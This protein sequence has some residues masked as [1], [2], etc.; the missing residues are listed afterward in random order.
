MLKSA[1]GFVMYRKHF[2]HINYKD[3]AAFLMLDKAF[4]RSMT[5]C[6]NTASRLLN[7]IC[8]EL[9]VK[10][11]AQEEMATLRKSLTAL[12]IESVLAGGLHEFIDQFHF[13]LNVVDRAIYQSFFAAH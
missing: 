4:P 3:V 9:G 8:G 6:I 7:A 10:V 5:R 13:N 2:H 11:P 12:P 1:N